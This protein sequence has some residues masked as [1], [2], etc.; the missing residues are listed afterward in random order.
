MEE[1]LDFSTQKSINEMIERARNEKEKV[2]YLAEFLLNAKVPTVFKNIELT[3]QYLNEISTKLE[4]N[5]VIDEDYMKLE[6]ACIEALNRIKS[7]LEKIEMTEEEILETDVINSSYSALESISKKLDEL[8]TKLLEKGKNSILEEVTEKENVKAKAMEKIKK[9]EK[10]I[11][12]K[13]GKIEEEINELEKQKMFLKGK[14]E[15]S[16]FGKK[17]LK[18]QIIE[19][20]TKIGEKCEELY[21]FNT[22]IKEE[23]KLKC[24]ND[25]NEVKI[26][27]D[28]I[29]E[30][31]ETDKENSKE[32]GIVEF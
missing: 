6:K 27:D 19:L 21:A 29:V 25:N 10:E 23:E 11:L 15:S 5:S 4:I 18:D 17:E 30:K 8:P 32:D 3:M 24:M 20:E 26:T 31:N 13:K 14:L 1:K 28:E 2:L 22:T 9:E 16:I 7:Q 12:E